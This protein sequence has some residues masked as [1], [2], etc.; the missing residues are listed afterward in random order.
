LDR[1]FSLLWYV[2]LLTGLLC[3]MNPGTALAAGGDIIISGPGLNN[4]EPVTITQ[5]QLRGESPLSDGTTYLKQQDIIYSTI[6]TWPTKSWYRGKGVF[7]T[8]LL[9]AAGGLNPDATQIRFISR[10]SFESNFSVQEIVYTPR[11]RF[12]NF[13]DT[14]L[15]GHLPGDA[16]DRVEVETIIAH[17]S[18]YAHDYD[19]ILNEENFS[20][21]DANHLLYGQRAV[22]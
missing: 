5:A 10:D 8:D 16:S 21:A 11:Y 18:F 6:N 19:D 9:E 2:F 1:F 15:P 20:K 3:I 12:P 22:T 7:L 13:M 17:E 14:G 4:S